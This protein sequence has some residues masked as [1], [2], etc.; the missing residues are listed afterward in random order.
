MGLI[1]DCFTDWNNLTVS[2]YASETRN[3]SHGNV[4]WCM[5][6]LEARGLMIGSWHD[7]PS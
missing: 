1:G 5:D 2:D 6:V 4:T 3:M 7:L